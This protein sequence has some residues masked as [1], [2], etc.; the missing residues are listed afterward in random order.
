AP[1]PEPL[2]QVVW[3]V[4][5]EVAVNAGDRAIAVRDP[6]T[7]LDVE[8]RDSLGLQVTCAYCENPVAGWVKE[9]DVLADPQSPATAAEGTLV[10]FALAVRNAAAWREV[11]SLVPVM[12][13]AF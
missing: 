6:F 12:T 10:E 2:P 8:G 5:P 11:P 4:R 1:D 7:R 3:T 9:A 13:S